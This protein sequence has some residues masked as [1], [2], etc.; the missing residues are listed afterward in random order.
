MFVLRDYQNSIIEQARMALRRTRAVQI[1]SPCGSGKTALTA[2]MIGTAHQRGHRAW[3]VV[4]RRE[5][6][7]Q[8]IAAFSK[9]G[10]PHAVCAAGFR[11]NV[12]APV[13][14]ASINT[15]ARRYERYPEP[16]L[17]VFD[18]SHHMA[19][20]TWRELYLK[21]PKAKII[22]LSATPKRG[23]GQGLKEF[24]GEMVSGPSIKWLIEHGYWARYRYFEPPGADLSG[25]HTRMEDFIQSE[26]AEVLDKPKITGSAVSHYK[27]YA[28]GKQAAAF[29]VSVEHSQHVA[30]EFRAAGI[31]AIHLDGKS[32]DTVRDGI[33]SDF[34]AGKIKVLSS[35]DLL[36]EGVD[37]PGIKCTIMLRPTQS[38]NIYMQTIGRGARP[39][40][41]EE[42]IIF[43]HVQN[44]SRHGYPD[45]DREW[46]LEGREAKRKVSS[47]EASIRIC[48]QCFAAT[49]S[50]AQRCSNCGLEFPIQAREIKQVDGEL[51]EVKS[52]PPKPKDPVKI[53]ARL[54][55][56]RADSIE[57]L[58]KLGISR[59][60]HPAKA[61][62]WGAY[63][64]AGR[65][66]K[67]TRKTA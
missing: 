65:Q 10:I 50:P 32:G 42:H 28:M 54:E 34:T 5:L 25:L 20:A 8:S 18:E 45:D 44:S 62:R 66:A 47:S 9:Q 53:A 26:S 52:R 1:Q 30:A 33:I 2:H 67:L 21:F 46:D 4:H 48:G 17:I 3:F 64:L 38:L 58:T 19:A 56:G 22:G 27:Q 31:P 41:G 23:D 61:A 13:Q 6:I 37:I 60:M 15:M 35:V 29:C 55:Q 14:I 57:A 36:V 49:R 12:K 7:N 43:D 39:D 51:V 59:G 11:G 24:F 40:E 63:V 16:A